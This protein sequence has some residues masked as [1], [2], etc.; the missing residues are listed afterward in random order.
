MT[1]PQDPF[2]TPQP[3]STTP[4]QPAPGGYG[5]G[6]AYGSAPAQGSGWG[7]DAGGY[8]QPPGPQ[9]TGTSGMAIAALVCSFLIPLV[10]LI[11]GFVAKSQIKKTGQGGNGLATAAIVISIASIVI[12]VLAVGGGLLSA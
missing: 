3:G 2:S 12:A 7:Q 4:P 10:G 11:L 8:G 5:A 1:S 6:P 9:K